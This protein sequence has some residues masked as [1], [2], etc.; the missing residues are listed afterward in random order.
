[1]SALPRRCASG[2]PGPVKGRG[3]KVQ[4]DWGRCNVPEAQPPEA[5][6]ICV[7]GACSLAVAK[8]EHLVRSKEGGGEDTG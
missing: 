6:P 5:V 8:V 2:T 4:Q 7:E 3:E 1:M